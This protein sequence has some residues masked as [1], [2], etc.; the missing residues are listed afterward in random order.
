[1]FF[2][3][4]LI[5]F[6]LLITTPSLFALPRQFSTLL[7][8]PLHPAQKESPRTPT[9][10]SYDN[11]LELLEKLESGEL[12][13]SCGPEELEKINHFLAN[14][15]KEGIL[16][17]E[18]NVEVLENDIQELLD[19]APFQL[20]FDSSD[21]VI[22]PAIYQSPHFIQCNWGSKQWRRTKRFVHKHK[23]AILI[24]AAVVVAVA[25]VVV[26][27][28]SSA[29]AAAASAATA[30]AATDKKEK[31]EM[32]APPL[33]PT[34]Q[35]PELKT[36]IE[37][38][39]S[40]LK[41]YVS[42]YSTAQPYTEPQAAKEA[43]LSAYAREFGSFL[44]HE[45][46]EGVADLAAAFPRL[47]DE[48]SYVGKAILPESLFPPSISAQEKYEARITAGHLK[49]D[50]LFATERA[51]NYGAG[52]LLQGGGVTYGMLPPPGQLYKVVNVPK[53]HNLIRGGQ[54]TVAMA[55]E[56]GFAHHEILQLEKA[57]SLEITI[58]KVINNVLCERRLIESMMQ[59]KRAE[60]YLK[61]YHKK[62]MSEDKV[63][64]LIQKT[65]TKTFPRPAG[66]PENYKVR[67]SDKGAGMVYR[68]PHDE[69]IAVRVMPGKPHSPFPCQQQPYVIQMHEGKAYDKFGNLVSKNAPE[70]HIPVEEFLYRK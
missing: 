22:I 42:L 39:V 68:H 63:R 15:A 12:E 37:E 58:N 46:L 21:F 32:A 59:T 29:S 65:E 62:Y 24:G 3:Y 66:I 47:Q 36:A 60:A 64:H 18:T 43:A 27:A 14:L 28:A 7:Q 56:F 48:L 4:R 69:N 70:A 53:L 16:P 35:T 50:Q 51:Q 54:S 38:H 2:F 10:F 31:K 9:L 1:M 8:T 23:T 49:I 67:V 25:I 45:T 34:T 19:E 17:K 55:E 52:S 11:V 6:V 13:K 5:A 33:V 20:A 30:A 61:P 44:A 40:S 41:E 57:G 26:V